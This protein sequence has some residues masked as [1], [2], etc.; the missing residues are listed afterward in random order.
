MH[1]YSII[2]TGIP[3][4]LDDC[5]RAAFHSLLCLLNIDE[6]NICKVLWQARL[7]RYTSNY[8]YSVMSLA[9]TEFI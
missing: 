7:A 6:D 9:W 8:E 3:N 1:W 5:H 4:D 2:L